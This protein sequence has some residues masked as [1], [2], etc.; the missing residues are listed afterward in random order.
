MTKA[1]TAEKYPDFDLDRFAKG[2]YI[3]TELVYA[4]RFTTTGAMFRVKGEVREVAKVIIPIERQ[5]GGKFT[6]KVTAAKARSETHRRGFEDGKA[7]GLISE[8]TE[9]VP[10]DWDSK[11]INITNEEVYGK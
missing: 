7:R 8:D 6:D 1:K 11:N 3:G 10:I 4:E 2:Q 5:F 9:Y